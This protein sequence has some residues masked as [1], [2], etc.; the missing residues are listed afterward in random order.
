MVKALVVLD[1]VPEA[2]EAF[3]GRTKRDMM[4]IIRRATD[5]VVKR[6]NIYSLPAML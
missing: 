5:Q 2:V 1:K 4:M 6:F 3:K